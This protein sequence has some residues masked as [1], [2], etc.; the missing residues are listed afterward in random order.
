MEVKTYIQNLLKGKGIEFSSSRNSLLEEFA[1]NQIN[2]ELVE[3]IFGNQEKI[4]TNWTIKN[5][6]ADIQMQH[7]V[8]PNAKELIPYSAK[9]DFEILNLTD[10]IEERFE[11]LEEFGLSFN[12]VTDTIEGTPTKSG[13]VKF[14]L[15]YKIK[16]ED[17][18]V[19]LNEKL[20]SLVINPDPKSLWVLIPSNQEAVFAKPDDTQ[21]F[22]RLGEK[23]IVVS[24][25]R[26][27]SH[28]KEGTSRDDD[29][30]FKYFEKT[31]WSLVVVSDG[32]GSAYLAR[33]GSKIACDA[34]VEYF[35]INNDS[36]QAIKLETLI[37]EYNQN[38]S[39]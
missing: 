20:I 22:D 14:K 32:A 19:E 1:N 15:L 11:G 36:E 33:A 31:D 8:I 38:K 9:I 5:R 7:I 6:I 4:M 29:F 18:T 34:V 35:E 13:D 27:R 28:G 10:L 12:T 3:I 26:G 24:S 2:R 17:E 16:G 30:S 37:D 39:I 25:K 21:S 23:N